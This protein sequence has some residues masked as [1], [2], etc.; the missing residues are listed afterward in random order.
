M[1]ITFGLNHTSYMGPTM[2]AMIVYIYCKPVLKE[3]LR[4]LAYVLSGVIV[5]VYLGALLPLSSSVFLQMFG[6][7]TAIG[8]CY[9]RDRGVQS[10]HLLSK[11][12]WENSFL[13]CSLQY[14]A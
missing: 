6:V 3:I 2:H 14:T 10:S 5:D 4:V 11:V 9:T 1:V 8:E 13:V 7:P 12:S